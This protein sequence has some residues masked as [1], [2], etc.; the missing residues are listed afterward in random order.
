[1][2]ARR[3]YRAGAPGQDRGPQRR[4]GAAPVPPCRWSESLSDP[5]DA[6]RALL[7][8]LRILAKTGDNIVGEVLRGAGTFTEWEHYPEND[9]YDPESHAQY[10]YH[11]HPPEDRAV[12]EHGHFHLFMR[13]KGMPAGTRP[14]NVPDFVPLPGDND[15]LSHIVAI[16]MDRFGMPRRLFTT[17]RWVTGET[18][19]PAPS[20]IRMIDRFSIDI[21]RP[22]WLVSLWITSMVRLFR[23]EIVQLV[24]ERDRAVARWN[25]EHPGAYVLEDRGLEITSIA[26]IDVEVRVRR[27]IGARESK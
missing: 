10:Y 23:P 5:V 12:E 4:S 26:D 22:N 7:E 15:A 14:S 6:A 21:V 27:L 24:Q 17:N 8:C 9:A 1:M 11:A 19:Y 3:S 25:R 2:T 16:S 20:V 13:P 18:W